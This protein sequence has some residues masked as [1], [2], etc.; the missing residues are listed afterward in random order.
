MHARTAPSSHVA[1]AE[2][3]FT[4][5]QQEVKNGQCEASPGSRDSHAIAD[6]A[7]RVSVRLPEICVKRSHNHR[8]LN[9]PRAGAAFA[10]VASMLR[11]LTIVSV[12]A[13][14]RVAGAQPGVEDP[15]PPPAAPAPQPYVEKMFIHGGVLITVDHFL[16]AAYFADAGLR[17]GDL[18]LAVHASIAKGGSLDAD[19][20]GDFYRW[21]A[22]VEA[23]SGLIGWGYTFVDLDLGY[24]HQTWGEPDPIA[25]EFEVHRGGLAIA[26]VGYDGGGDHIRVRATFELY[27]YHREFVEPMTTSWD[28]GGGITLSFGYRH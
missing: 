8:D 17:L 20:G 26:R 11:F 23:R 27:K 2:P 3:P 4:P 15:P 9:A 22:G 6:G 14:A 24:Q 16:N 5:R 21:T 7:T 13:I 10:D 12:L 18:P 19:N 1:A 28:T 25:D